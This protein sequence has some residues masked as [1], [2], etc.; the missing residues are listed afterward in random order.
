MLLR[1]IC[2]VSTF[3]T[4][5]TYNLNL[6]SI[7]P[8]PSIGPCVSFG[9]AVDWRGADGTVNLSARCRCSTAAAVRGAASQKFAGMAA[10]FHSEGGCGGFSE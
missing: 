8:R 9:F 3:F 4:L 6:Y 2:Y 7:A 1:P 5:N 10:S